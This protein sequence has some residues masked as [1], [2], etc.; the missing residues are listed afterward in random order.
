[1]SSN[2]NEFSYQYRGPEKIKYHEFLPIY[3]DKLG[4]SKAVKKKLKEDLET[5]IV[6]VKEKTEECLVPISETDQHQKRNRGGL[7]Y[8]KITR[9]EIVEDCEKLNLPFLGQGMDHDAVVQKL[10]RKYPVIVGYHSNKYGITDRCFY[11]VMKECLKEVIFQD[12][13][14]DLL[15]HALYLT[16]PLRGSPNDM[17]S[18]FPSLV[19]EFQPKLDYLEFEP[20]KKEEVKQAARTFHSQGNHF[21]VSLRFPLLF[22]TCE[23]F[24]F[25]AND[26]MNKDAQEAFESSS[27]NSSILLYLSKDVDLEYQKY[28]PFLHCLFSTGD[29]YVDFCEISQK[30]PELGTC[31]HLFDMLFEMGPSLMKPQVEEIPRCD[32]TRLANFEILRAKVNEKWGNEKWAEHKKKI[33]KTSSKAEREEIEEKYKNVAF[34]EA[35]DEPCAHFGPCGPDTPNCSCKSWCTERCQCDINCSRRYPGCRCS[36]GQCGTDECPCVQLEYECM[37]GACQ[38]CM[39]HEDDETVPKEDKCKNHVFQRGEECLIENRQSSIAG[40]GA[41]LK[42]DVK[43][44]QFV[45]EYVGEHISEEEF[46]RR[47]ALDHFR[48]SY[49]FELPNCQ[50]SIDAQYAGNETRFINH[51]DNPNLESF[52]RH[53]DG[54]PRIGFNAMEDLKAETE[55]A[56]DYQYSP[57]DKEIY[58]FTDPKDRIHKKAGKENSIDEKNAGRL[59]IKRP[60]EEPVDHLEQADK[61]TEMPKRRSLRRQN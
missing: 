52:Y 23:K 46:K 43:K 49:H 4:N 35:L 31:A 3:W 53:V 2:N 51:D 24:C 17:A 56:F 32:E 30:Y 45:G 13:N 1:M 60:A 44:G 19:E 27:E 22:S 20:W 41:F 6:M 42:V 61:E 15:Y 12:L 40:T 28:F 9:N 58:F 57:L 37:K 18:M 16:F 10:L 25:L 59:S 8:R 21:V 7:G 48:M 33:K 11:F 29:F 38:Y 47:S 36:P 5:V 26:L 54:K 39:D 55:L 34:Y 14:P 50:G